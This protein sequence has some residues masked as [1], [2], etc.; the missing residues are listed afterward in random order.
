MADIDAQLAAYQAEIDHIKTQVANST[1]GA[2]GAA[3]RA[4]LFRAWVIARQEY[5]MLL[6]RARARRTRAVT[7]G[8]P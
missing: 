5:G 8:E 2:H 1:P 6:R 7:I 3:Q 4:E